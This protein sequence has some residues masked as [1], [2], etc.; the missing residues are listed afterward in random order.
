[1]KTICM[2]TDLSPGAD[3]AAVRA[4]TLARAFGARLELLR[5]L[6]ED[7]EVDSRVAA[8][9][10]LSDVCRALGHLD[11]L[12]WQAE[13][14]CGAPV[15]TLAQWCA[16]RSAD[17]IVM[18]PH[19]NT[20]AFDRLRD[21][22]LEALVREV[23]CPALLVREPGHRP[24]RRLICAVDFSPA[25]LAATQLAVQIAPEALTSLVHA[26]QIPYHASVGAPGSLG[27]MPTM[28]DPLPFIADAEARA[29][30][31]RTGLPPA[32]A[33]HPIAIEQGAVLNV[34]ARKIGAEAP[35]L[36][37]VGAHGRTGAVDRLLGS[38]AADLIRDPPCDLLVAPAPAA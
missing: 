36:L 10:E 9:E 15:E 13:V 32:L 26:V 16:E 28:M 14:R 20:R 37:A 17:L 33:N 8:R 18:G 12:S 2:A 38:L 19:D 35:D 11:D 21:T 5:V 27:E 6:P 3:R 22:T 4:A 24:Y 1:M 23:G 34:L 29:K 30:D 25:A 31:W 7:T